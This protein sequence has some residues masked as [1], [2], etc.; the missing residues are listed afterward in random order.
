MFVMLI[1]AGYCVEGQLVGSKEVRSRLIEGFAAV[2][3]TINFF[4]FFI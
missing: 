4:T 1:L 2:A 3:V